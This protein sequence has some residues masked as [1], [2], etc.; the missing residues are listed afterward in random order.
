MAA[1]AA[2]S[3]G[4]QN[5]IT[6]TMAPGGSTA[7]EVNDSCTNTLTLTQVTAA[8]L[9]FSEPGTSLCVAGT[10]TFTLHGQRLAYKW[11]DGVE[12]NT[13]TLHRKK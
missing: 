2:P 10:V 12:Q 7:A 8:T 13:A 4:L 11:T 9:T 1:L 5:N 6:F 3:I